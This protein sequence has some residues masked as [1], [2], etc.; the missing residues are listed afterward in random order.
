M[1][2]YC[3]NELTEIIPALLFKLNTLL[4]LVGFKLPVKNW[5]PSS[6][7]D[8]QIEFLEVLSDQLLT[9]LPCN[10]VVQIPFDVMMKCLY[11]E[12]WNLAFDIL[13]GVHWI[14]HYCELLFIYVDLIII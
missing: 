5:V 4:L 1:P 6:L 12:I 7:V 3:T 9:E 14:N 13:K 8:G 2:N 11:N 10:L